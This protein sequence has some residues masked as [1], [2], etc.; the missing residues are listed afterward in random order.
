M[1]IRIRAFAI[2]LT[3]AWAAIGG[4]GAADVVFSIT[5]GGKTTTFEL[6]LNPVPLLNNVS[7]VV[8]LGFHRDFLCSD[9]CQWDAKASHG[10]VFLQHGS[11]ARRIFR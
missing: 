5:G 9:H 11:G 3:L 4:V 7:G 2:G 10:L 1:N 6:P 8:I